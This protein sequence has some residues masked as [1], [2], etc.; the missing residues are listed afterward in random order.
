VKA[1]TLTQPWAELVVAGY[2]RVETRAWRTS[3]RGPLAIHSARNMPGWAKAIADKLSREGLDLGEM[4]KGFIVG[5]VV[6]L[7]IQ[8]VEAVRDRLS[9]NELRLGDY[10]D[11]RYAWQLDAPVKYGEPQEKTGRLGLWDWMLA[12]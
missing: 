3:Y 6:L 8:P 1:L 4:P 10:T 9:A 2:K 7:E 11:G 5:E 12:P